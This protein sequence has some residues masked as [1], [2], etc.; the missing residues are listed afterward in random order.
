MN[1]NT[2][3]VYTGICSQVCTCLLCTV[4]WSSSSKSDKVR[5]TDVSTITL[6]SNQLTTGRR[7]APVPQV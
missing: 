2:N 6:H 5:L 4:Q 3:A 7:S 1:L